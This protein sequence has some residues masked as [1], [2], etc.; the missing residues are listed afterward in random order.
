MIEGKEDVVQKGVG[1][2]WGGSLVV[3]EWEGLGSKEKQEK[4]LHLHCSCRGSQH[5]KE[6]TAPSYC[7]TSALKDSSCFLLC[8]IKFPAILSCRL[9]W[10]SLWR[11][12]LLHQPWLSGHLPKPHSLWMG[13]HRSCWKT[14]HCQLLLH[15]HWR[16]WRLCP[17]LSSTLWW[18]RC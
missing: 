11:P 6:T 16:S 5:L 7:L 3:R 17:Q 18:T 4:G 8:W 1:E 2:A 12:W 14:C 9:W 13:H 10:N 15:Q